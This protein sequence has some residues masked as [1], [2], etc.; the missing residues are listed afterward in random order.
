MTEVFYYNSKKDLHKLELYNISG[1]IYLE[2]QFNSCFEILCIIESGSIIYSSKT[3]T[4]IEDSICTL[5]EDLI[6]Q[7]N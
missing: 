2:K 7:P 4:L 3:F 5:L 6:S 1:Q